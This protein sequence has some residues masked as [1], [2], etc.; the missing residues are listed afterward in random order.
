[1][2][3]EA[4]KLP[5]GYSPLQ[6]YMAGAVRVP[7]FPSHSCLL[8][9]SP[10]PIG[11]CSACILS[12]QLLLPWFPLFPP[13]GRSLLA[14]WESPAQRRCPT[15]WQRLPYSFFATPDSTFY[16]LA[17]A[18]MWSA[19]AHR[20]GACANSDTFLS[21]AQSDPEAPEKESAGV[22]VPNAGGHT[23]ATR[24]LTEQHSNGYFFIV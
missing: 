7:C 15:C 10:H 19:E 18:A 11:L 4:V 22:Q 9:I 2:R 21:I 1:M 24:S 16:L 3:I 17:E 23:A 6:S 12:A 5:A 14:P 20:G 8:L 13:M